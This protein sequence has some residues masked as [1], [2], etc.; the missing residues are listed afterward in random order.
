MTINALFLGGTSI[1]LIQGKAAGEGQF[2]A[3]VG[4]S[5]TNAAIIS[6]KLGLKTGLLSRIGNDP[7]GNF[8]REFLD[9]LKIDTKGIIQ[10]SDIRTPLAI[11]KVDKCKN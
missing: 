1:D 7:L 6:A 11:A 2:T 4:G 5:V 9:S 10:D 8:A 3:S